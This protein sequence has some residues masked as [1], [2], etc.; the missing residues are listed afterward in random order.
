MNFPIENMSL[1]SSMSNSQGVDT[2]VIYDLY[3]VS[4]HMGGLGGGHYIAHILN[5]DDK[6][7]YIKD[8]SSVTKCHTISPMSSAYVLFYRKK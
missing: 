3:G 8:D 1:K 4:N 2:K 5:S 7:W 6:Q